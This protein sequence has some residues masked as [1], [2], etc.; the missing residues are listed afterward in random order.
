MN[1]AIAERKKLE[2]DAV[3]ASDE[4]Q[5]HKYEIKML[6]EKV[7]QI[8]II[9]KKREEEL[10][11]EKEYSA[12]LESGRKS[13]EAQV[14]DAQAKLEEMEEHTKRESKKISISLESRVIYRELFLFLLTNFKEFL[15]KSN[16]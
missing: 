2:T 15:K 11:N 6:E 5:E 7:R 10:K 3:Q 8:T 4:L 16:S 9:N 1:K 14:R 12:E 13:M